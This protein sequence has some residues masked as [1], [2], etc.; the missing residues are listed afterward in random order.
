[1]I[2][3]ISDKNAAR[4]VAGNLLEIE[5]I[6]LRVENPFTW[7][8]GWNSPIYCDNRVSLSFPEL[9][10]QIKDLLVKQIRAVF[11]DV[12]AISGVATAG[13][14]QGALI[15]EA[16]GLPFSYVRSKPKGHG[17]EN[18]IEGRVKE[19]AKTVV[20]EDLIS[21]GGSSLKA[22]EALKNAN[23]N[24][25]GLAA[26]FSY[27]FAIANENFEKAGITAFV[28]SDYNYLLEEALKTGYIKENQVENLKEWR[29]N[30]A[31]WN[32]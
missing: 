23:V 21:T 29:D 17:M 13:I 14:P 32:K 9:R 19:N 20:I 8:S 12:E 6:K 24:V 7:S 16:M 4:E 26:I 25:V 5:A 15:A 10:T 28:L 22:I 3:E 18:L 31:G 30:P 1:M 2:L 27:D 11:P